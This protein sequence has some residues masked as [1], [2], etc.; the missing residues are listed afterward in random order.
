MSW[1][2]DAC[3]RIA[4][5]FCVCY[6]CLFLSLIPSADLRKFHF[7]T[8]SL[9]KNAAE[10]AVV[11]DEVL[12]DRQ[13]TLALAVQS[14][15]RPLKRGCREKGNLQETEMR[16]CNKKE[17]GKSSQ[18]KCSLNLSNNKCRSI[19]PSCQGQCQQKRRNFSLVRNSM[20]GLLVIERAESTGHSLYIVNTLQRNLVRLKPFNPPS[21]TSKYMG[22][23]T[24]NSPT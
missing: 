18:P 17:G 4:K 20:S 24:R 9:S 11:V 15:L 3:C 16:T 10:A 22:A 14:L 1:K 7:W 23:E 6:V 5:T 13:Q 2:S 19:Q 21:W 8:R 12:L